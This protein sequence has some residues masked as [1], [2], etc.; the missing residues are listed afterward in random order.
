MKVLR[1]FIQVPE[2]VPGRTHLFEYRVFYGK[3]GR[4]IVGFNNERGKGYHRP[5]SQ[6]IT[7]QELVEFSG[8]GS[9]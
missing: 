7:I 1:I 9:G 4:R 3:D 5:L 6:L 8:P 2:P